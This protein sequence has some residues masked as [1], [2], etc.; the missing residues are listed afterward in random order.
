MSNPAVVE[1]S[2]CLEV[3]KSLDFPQVTLTP[4]CGHAATV[5]FVCVESFLDSQSLNGLMDRLSCPECSELL[6]YDAIQDF[7]TPE[8]F[9]RYQKY[10]VDQ[11]IAR[12]INFTWCPLGRQYCSRH[13]V[14]WHAEHTCDEYDTFLTDPTFRSKTQINKKHEKTQSLQDEQLSQRIREADDLFAQ[15][16]MNEKQAS[17]ARLEAEIERRRIAQEKAAREAQRRRELEEAKKLLERKKQEEGLTNER[18][19]YLTKPCPQCNAPIEKNGGCDHMHC[20]MAIFESHTQRYLR[21]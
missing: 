12:V 2:S 7:A 19:R 18:F 14:P 15:S 16:L 1:C 17:Q 21:K 5:C 9:E 8:V 6:T 13:L 4:R 20:F 10:S 3:K 11:L